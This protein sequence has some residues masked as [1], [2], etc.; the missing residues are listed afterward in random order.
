MQCCSSACVDVHR[1]PHNCGACGNACTATQFCTGTQCD[2]AVFQNLCANPAVSVIYGAFITD[3]EA[4]VS[5]GQAIAATCP[6]D[7][8]I[9]VSTV[10]QAQ[11]GTALVPGD[12]G[13]RPNTGAGS[14]MVVGGGDYGQL[15]VA[16]MDDH[17]LTPVYGTNDGTTAHFMQRSTGLPLVTVTDAVL[18]GSQGMIQDYVALVLSVEPQSSTL[19]FFG[20]GI[21]GQGTLAAGYFGPQVLPTLVNTPLDAG[22]FVPTYYI[23]HWVDTNKDMTPDNGDSFTLVASGA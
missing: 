16:Y 11:P 9:A 4:G 12:A 22:L 21:T 5:L 13:W 19:C 15:A 1:D 23:Y 18:M 17:A 20:Y 6:A 14:T 7:A 2:N 8:G 3:Y 10:V